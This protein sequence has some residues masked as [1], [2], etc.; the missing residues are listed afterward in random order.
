MKL[1]PKQVVI[2]RKGMKD[3]S[4]ISLRR[5]TYESLLVLK[6]KLGYSL[7]ELTNMAVEEFIK[8]LEITPPSE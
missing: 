2:Q 7:A 5:S 4:S 6:M 3:F 1:S 8:N